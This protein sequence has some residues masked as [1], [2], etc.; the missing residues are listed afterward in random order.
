MIFNIILYISILY[1]IEE[2]ALSRR[3]RARQRVGMIP[4]PRRSPK[5]IIDV[6]INITWRLM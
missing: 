1:Y 2:P 6:L 5:Y 4:V 3:S